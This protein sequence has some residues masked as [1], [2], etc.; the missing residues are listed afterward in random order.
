V[1]ALALTGYDLECALHRVLTIEDA[2][3]ALARWRLGQ[4]QHSYL[5]GAVEEHE[6]L[7]ALSTSATHLGLQLDAAAPPRHSSCMR[8]RLRCDAACGARLGDTGAAPPSSG[9]RPSTDRARADLD[10]AA[11]RVV[12]VSP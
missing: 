9:T 5:G 1:Q 7:G 8:P 4:R 3:G 11:T 10:A 2:I 6:R 12:K